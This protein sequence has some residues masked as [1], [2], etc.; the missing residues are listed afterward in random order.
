MTGRRWRVAARAPRLCP[1][2][3]YPPAQQAQLLRSVGAHALSLTGV[4]LGGDDPVAKC[5][6]GHAEIA[7]D[8]TVACGGST[9]RGEQPYGT[10]W[11]LGLIPTR[12]QILSPSNQGP[13][14][15]SLLTPLT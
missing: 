10:Q 1:G 9:A 7:D 13:R 12:R 5:L 3:P 14:T 4:D 8:L 6:F 2:H 15:R 11:S